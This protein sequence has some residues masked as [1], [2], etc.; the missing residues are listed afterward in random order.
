METTTTA[1]AEY[2]L[3]EAGLEALRGRYS[4]I[5]FD[6][7]S[8]KGN[9]EARQARKEL[10]TLRTSLE[11]K[12]KE[13]QAPLR[14]RAALINEEAK[15][16]TAA[17]LELE[18]P[19][20]EAIKAD[21]LRRERERKE[22][23]AA[24]AKRVAKHR[25]A[26][27]AITETALRA[28]G[29]SSDAIATEIDALEAFEVGEDFDEFQAG[30]QAAKDSTL[31][32]LRTLHGAALAN[33][34]EARRLAEERAE[35][36]RQKAEQERKAQEQAAAL[37]EQQRV[38]RERLEAERQERARKDAEA[39]AER[40]RQERA[41]REARAEQERLARLERERQE[42]IAR[43]ARAAQQAQEDAARAE[44]Q[45]I[46]AEEIARQR[47]ELDAQAEAMAEQQ[48]VAAVASLAAQAEQ[49]HEGVEAVESLV[50]DVLA[51]N[52]PTVDEVV[53]ELQRALNASE[54][55]VLHW[56]VNLAPEIEDRFRA[57]IRSQA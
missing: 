16:I 3:V 36:A 56:L 29:K 54:Y 47:A 19:I 38:E 30:A 17:V 12:R 40:E 11:A 27:Q 10:V 25:D 23:D 41:D 33:E 26:I 43:E 20:Y 1:I 5:V 55:A 50:D 46:A 49:I 44:A 57:L 28:V 7:R 51:D 4:D 48:R 53:K 35:L 45:R 39:R 15:R 34:N 2:N 24:E 18:R 21:E 42:Q 37:A 13:L 14:D 22:R 9:T 6:L 32:Q 8:V 31:A 52:R